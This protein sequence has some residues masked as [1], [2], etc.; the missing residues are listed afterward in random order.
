MTLAG[1]QLENVTLEEAQKEVERCV[2]EYFK[3]LQ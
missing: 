3:E 1:A 2:D